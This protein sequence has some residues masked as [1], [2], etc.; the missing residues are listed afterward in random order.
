MCVWVAL[1]CHQV[2]V[3]GLRVLK[4]EHRQIDH[5]CPPLFAAGQR[6]LEP[7]AADCAQLVS[8][9]GIAAAQGKAA[10]HWHAAALEDDSLRKARPLPV[11]IEKSSNAYAFRVIATETRVDAAHPLKLIDEPR[12]RQSLRAEPPTQTKKRSHDT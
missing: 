3:K 4:R 7:Q 6:K 1:R 2:V 9:V 5:C 11:A 10:D 8:G 12:R